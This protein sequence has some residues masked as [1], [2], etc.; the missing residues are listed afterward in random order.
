MPTDP[1]GPRTDVGPKTIIGPKQ[2][3]VAWDGGEGPRNPASDDWVGPKMPNA[4]W[5]DS[6]GPKPGDVIWGGCWPLFC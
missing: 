3:V 6:V 1:I 5:D 4:A 2:D